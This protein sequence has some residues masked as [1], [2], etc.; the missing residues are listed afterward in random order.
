MRRTRRQLKYFVE[1]CKIKENKSKGD[2]F[3]ANKCEC[4]Y[5]TCPLPRNN[6][7]YLWQICYIIAGVFVLCF[8]MEQFT[9]FQTALF[10]APILMDISYSDSNSRVMFFIRLVFGTG[11]AIILLGCVL[12]VGGIIVDQNES[13]AIVAE[14]SFLNGLSL[15][16]KALGTI[17]TAN[18]LVPVVY[19][20]CSPCQ[21]NCKTIQS[22]KSAIKG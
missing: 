17:I 22:V 6:N 3:L 13:F 2:F 9:F 14:A 8:K 21:K 10:I 18:I 20:Y 11:N 1:S 5:Q 16:K 12:G 15:S 4:I 7:R 19:Y